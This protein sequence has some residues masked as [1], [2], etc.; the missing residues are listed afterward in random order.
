MRIDWDL[1]NWILAQHDTLNLQYQVFSLA[2]WLA[3]KK[4]VVISLFDKRKVFGFGV[5]EEFQTG[6][7]IACSESIERICAR[8]L[9]VST[10]GF[11]A[12]TDLNI[13]KT[14]SWREL[15]ERDA[16]LWSWHFGKGVIPTNES[17]E[18]GTLGNEMW[19]FREIPSAD[20]TLKVGIAALERENGGFIVGAA[21]SDRLKEAL[22]KAV[23]EVSMVRAHQ[24]SHKVIPI[25]LDEF[26]RLDH[27][28]P[29]HHLRLA[30]D[31]DYAKS[32]R[33]WL[34]SNGAPRSLLELRPEILEMKIPSMVERSPVRVVRAE[35]PQLL[36]M[37]FGKAIYPGLPHPMG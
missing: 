26:S 34:N 24:E 14:N 13:A 37:Y 31:P 32:I 21:C 33:T 2:P 28:T 30:L 8:E 11:S 9:G 16:F 7:A 4:C 3:D 18:A 19:H 27:H 36:Q 17:V 1:Y 15:I 25:T 20:A 22:E 29:E 6:L 12:H 35:E 10:N 23:K 5:H